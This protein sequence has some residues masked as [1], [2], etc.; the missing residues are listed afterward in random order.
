MADMILP[1]TNGH[2]NLEAI[3]EQRMKN[4]KYKLNRRQI[5]M[6]ALSKPVHLFWD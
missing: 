2:V 3:K 1:A 5:Q 6:I 4:K